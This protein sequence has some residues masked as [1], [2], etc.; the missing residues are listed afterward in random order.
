MN[1]RYLSVDEICRY[2][3]VKSKDTIYDWINKKNMPGNKIG[4]LWKFRKEEIDK[5]I[6]SQKS[7][8]KRK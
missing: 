8:H 2:L 3:S 4:R 7:K 6:K 1:D 5:W